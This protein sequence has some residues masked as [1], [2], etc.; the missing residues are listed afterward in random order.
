MFIIY[1]FS[2]K[3]IYKVSIKK[4]I[5]IMS[6][7]VI[8]Q[9]ILDDNEYMK[10]ETKKN[11]IV[12]HHTAGGHNPIWTIN[13]WNNDT[14]GRIATAFTV[15][16]KSISGDNSLDGLVCMAFEPKYWGWHLGVKGTNGKLDKRTIGIEVCNYGPITKGKDGKFYNYV[17][18]PMP[19]SDVYDLGFVWRG[20]RYFHKY[21]NAQLDSLKNLLGWLSQEF[22]IDLKSHQPWSAKS[23]EVNEDALSGESGVWTHV[24]YRKDKTDCHPQPELI[25]MLNSL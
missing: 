18:K 15:G 20:Y 14:R 21:T 2:K 10:V 8:Q 23:F 4:R 16:G 7:T 19:N 22:G 17:K 25:Q 1:P 3:W 24:N 9:H 5:M 6:E 13:S 12:L 11:A